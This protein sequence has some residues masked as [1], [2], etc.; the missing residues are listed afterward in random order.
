MKAISPYH[1]PVAVKLYERGIIAFEGGEMLAFSE[2][3]K[4]YPGK[5]SQ[6]GSMWLP[7][8]MHSM[9]TAGIMEFLLESWLPSHIEAACSLPDGKLRK[10]CRFLALTHDIG[11]LT[12]SF[13]AR[14]LETLPEVRSR[15]EYEGLS[16]GYPK[17]YKET[18]KTKHAMASEA[19]LIRCGCP[20]GAAAIAGAHH[21]RT[22]PSGLECRENPE[23]YPWN[24]YHSD[25]ART[26][27]NN[28]REEW[29]RFALS[30]AGI[31]AVEDIPQPTQAAQM[32]LTG[33]LIMAD[34]LA[35][36][37][38]YFPLIPI[39]SAGYLL[40][41]RARADAAWEKLRLSESWR[42][43]SF[44]LDDEG[45]EDIFGFSPNEVQKL[46][47]QSVNDSDGSGIFI[48]EAQMGIG[49]T[50][51]AL[52]AAEVLASRS[53]CGGVYFG[54]P[55]QATANGLFERLASWAEKKAEGTRQSI[56]L[57]HG[58]AEL[59]EE[60]R[61]LFHGNADVDEDG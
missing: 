12:P 23:A 55:T 10:L 13:A 30:E 11:K 51:A 9:D 46:M 19:I 44:A 37:T 1:D 5:T 24:Y 41:V 43:I 3:L 35:S 22:Q 60:Y 28:L 58:M 57:A 18:G 50:E 21:G 38:S 53:G 15:L 4:L 56:R 26:T 34:W 27:W 49:K 20:Q 16:V 29:L 25:D 31:S 48:L 47:L 36:N 6:D 2:I 59:N 39:D 54:L 61:A 7:F 14:I 17:D 32:L 8:W 33:L 40:L 42:P 52:A 45:F